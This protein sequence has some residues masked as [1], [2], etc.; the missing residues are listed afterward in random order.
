MSLHLH[1]PPL[2]PAWRRAAPVVLAIALLLGLT[3][4]LPGCT[5]TGTL[6]P[7]AQQIVDVTCQ[8]DAVMQPIVVPVIVAAT[9]ATPAGAPA[10]A[11]AGL[12]TL[13]LHPAVIAACAQYHS[14]PVAVVPAPIVAAP[15]AKPA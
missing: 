4:L 5:S 13:L 7:Q 3:W 8:Q 15:V 10:A 14:K 9:A 12:D 6:T 2:A 11:A 1:H